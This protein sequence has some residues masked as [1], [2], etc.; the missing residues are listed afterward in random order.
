MVSLWDLLLLMCLVMP[1]MGAYG[2]AKQAHANWA[3]Y[4][5]A[6]VVGAGLG[7][8]C[9]WLAHRFGA[10]VFARIEGRTDVVQERIARMV[11]AGLGIWILCSLALGIWAAE[12][13]L[14]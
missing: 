5:L 13:M 2:V 9:S 12:V 8:L 11:Y 6:L 7:F 10:M 4:G 14:G 3:G 1:G